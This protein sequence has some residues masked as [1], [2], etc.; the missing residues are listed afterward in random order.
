M[1]DT[2][3][4]TNTQIL[5]HGFDHFMITVGNVSTEIQNVTLFGIVCY[6]LV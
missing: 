2:F 1:L 3:E 6:D 5:Y 4:D